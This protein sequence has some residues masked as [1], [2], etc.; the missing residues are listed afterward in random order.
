MRRIALAILLLSALVVTG[1]ATDMMNIK[2]GRLDLT[3]VSGSVQDQNHW[4]LWIRNIEDARPEGTRGTSSI[5]TM[6]Q[7]FSDTDSRV[8]ISPAPDEYLREQLSLYLLHKEMEASNEDK[9]LVFLDIKLKK[10]EIVRDA[11]GVLDQVTFF[12]EYEVTFVTDA[13]KVL[14][15]INL[16]EKRWVK[17]FTPFSAQE[18][19]ENLM[20]NTLSNT[21]KRLTDSDMYKKAATLR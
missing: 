19:L 1:C 20:K 16:P 7:R 12:M 18:S 6:D 17:G 10:F 8:T 3:E 13:G 4:S 14:G 11:S 2:P 5:G 15:T 9:A 21:F